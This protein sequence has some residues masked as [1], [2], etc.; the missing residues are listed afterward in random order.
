MK[1]LI[2]TCI[3]SKALRHKNPNKTIINEL[4]QLIFDAR[5]AIIGPIRQEL[6]SGIA[7][8]SQFNKLKN[9]LSAFEDIPLK[10]NHFIKGAEFNNLCK[11]K[12][13]QGSMIDFLICATASIENLHIFTEDKDFKHYE[14]V[15][16]IK[17][18]AI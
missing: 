7:D 4:K 8:R 12:G 14:K 16:P 3:W 2:D 11:S 9:K 10:T 5:V 6:L 18:Y 15:L 1:V 13:I 17:L